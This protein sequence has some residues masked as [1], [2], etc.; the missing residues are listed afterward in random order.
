MAI[1]E[2][3]GKRLGVD[4]FANGSIRPT[5]VPVSSMQ[6]IVQ[7]VAP[8]AASDRPIIIDGSLFGMLREMANGEAQIVV[9]ENEGAN[10]RRARMWYSRF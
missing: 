2:E 4:G 10:A 1:W 8:G 9:N 5:Y 7:V 3:T 6:T